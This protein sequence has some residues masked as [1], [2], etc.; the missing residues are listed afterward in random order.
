MFGEEKEGACL[1]FR[2]NLRAGPEIWSEAQTRPLLLLTKHC[3]SLAYTCLFSFL[4][5][6]NVKIAFGLIILLTIRTICHDYHSINLCKKFG[7]RVHT[8]ATTCICFGTMVRQRPWSLF[9]TP[10]QP[11]G[12]RE[13]W[14]L[15]S[16]CA[17]VA[18]YLHIDF[19]CVVSGQ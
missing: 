14:L 15:S 5:L 16:R 17:C 2:P 4:M 7:I 19:W 6:T 8:P 18:H 12:A 11:I 3:K 10:H 1:Y 13:H 9:I